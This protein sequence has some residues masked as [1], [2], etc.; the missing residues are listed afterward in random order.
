MPPGDCAK[1]RLAGTVHRCLSQT[2][3]MSAWE[4]KL[5]RIRKGAGDGGDLDSG[6]GG[7]SWIEQKLKR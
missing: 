2:E 7:E 1:L 6:T 3:K 5:N 4:W